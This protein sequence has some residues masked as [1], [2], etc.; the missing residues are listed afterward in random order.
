MPLFST[1]KNKLQYILEK[2]QSNE[3]TQND[4]H[5]LLNKKFKNVSQN[6]CTK[7]L[8]ELNKYLKTELKKG[9]ESSFHVF[10]LND[11]GISFMKWFG[12]DGIDVKNIVIVLFTLLT[13]IGTIKALFYN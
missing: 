12:Y 2:V 6:D 1:H 10:K 11:E 3:L 5:Y 9:N 7:L 8:E 4:I 13:A